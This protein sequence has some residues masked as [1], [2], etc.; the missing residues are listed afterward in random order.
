ME[1]IFSNKRKRT[2]NGVLVGA[3]LPIRLLADLNSE[4]ESAKPT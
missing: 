2:L 4:K 3:G 1:Q